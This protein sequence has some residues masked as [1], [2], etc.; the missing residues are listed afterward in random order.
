[1][2]GVCAIALL[3][4][5]WLL[6]SSKESQPEK[7]GLDVAQSDAEHLANMLVKEISIYNQDRLRRARLHGDATS[8]SRQARTRRCARG[9]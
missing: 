7:S 2:I 9:L 1:M 4:L 3:G 6:F 8:M 5:L